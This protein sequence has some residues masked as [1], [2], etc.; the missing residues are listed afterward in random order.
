MEIFCTPRY[1]LN[2]F[3]TLAANCLCHYHGKL[4]M[5]ILTGCKNIQLLPGVFFLTAFIMSGKK[6]FLAVDV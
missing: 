3:T 6:D 4:Q 1:S 2:K 5:K